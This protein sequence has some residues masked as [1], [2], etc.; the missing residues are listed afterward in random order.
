MDVKN[1]HLVK[2]IQLEGLRKLGNPYSFAE[3][4][5]N[6]GVDEI[7]LVD[8]VASLYQRSGM[9]DLVSRLA[10]ILRVPLTVVGGIR[11]L[12]DAEI[13][14]ESG[15]DKVGINSA[16]FQKPNLMTEIANSFGEQAV[17]ASVEVKK[18]FQSKFYCYVNNG[19]DNTRIELSKWIEVLN[20]SGCGE[21]FLT[22]IDR[23]GGL[24]G[25]DLGITH[26]ARALTDLPIIYSGGVSS[27]ED[28]LSLVNSG[29]DAVAIASMFHYENVPISQ[30][31]YS[32]AANQIEVRDD[33]MTL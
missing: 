18:S 8:I 4:Y 24:N 30:I 23:D 29:V 5:V 31:K 1:E 16:L 28:V 20:D 12:R 13:M 19:R 26:T 10:S 11:S 15:A 33:W 6:E 7:I 32:L 22:S 21:I 27:P 14:F 2:G 9:Y 25:P 17:I 3:K